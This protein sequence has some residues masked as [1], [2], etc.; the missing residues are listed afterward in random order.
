MMQGRFTIYTYCWSS[1]CLLWFYC[2]LHVTKLT[3]WTNV[4]RYK[5][6]NRT[7]ITENL[8]QRGRGECKRGKMECSKQVHIQEENMFFGDTGFYWLLLSDVPT[9]KF[10]ITYRWAYRQQD[11]AK[12]AHKLGKKSE[13]KNT[14]KTFTEIYKL[15][16][17]DHCK[18]ILQV[19]R[20]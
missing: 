10:S 16:Q 6:E 13:K 15:S 4:Y 14:D 12:C 20:N 3:Q 5:E 11:F 1:V 9:L 2:S 7:K 17:I 19:N 8:R 18:L